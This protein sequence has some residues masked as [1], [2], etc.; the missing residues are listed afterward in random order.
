MSADVYG[1]HFGQLFRT[2]EGEFGE[3]ILHTSSPWRWISPSGEILCGYGDC[4]ATM[5]DMD[6]S[7]AAF[8]VATNE[9]TIL[10][11]NRSSIRVMA[12]DR[13]GEWARII[14]YRDASSKS[15]HLVLDVDG[16]RERLA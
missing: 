8:D 3:R 14:R 12:C 2:P 10:L 15:S 11:D 16:S 9:L 6:L 13:S 5:R 4:P 7:V 1:F